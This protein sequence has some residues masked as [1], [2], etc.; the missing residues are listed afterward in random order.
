MGLAF[1]SY[2]VVV[3]SMEDDSYIGYVSG[4]VI[5]NNKELFLDHAYFKYP[6]PD[7]KE[8]SN[9]ICLMMKKKSG[10]DLNKIIIQSELSQDLW[11]RRYGF[12]KSKEIIYVKQFSNDKLQRED[13]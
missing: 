10:M 5:P 1:S 2:T 12:Q 8:V 11:L 13:T 4:H 9:I 6:I 7:I 3:R